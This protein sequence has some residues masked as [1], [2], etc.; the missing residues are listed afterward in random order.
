MPINRAHVCDYLAG[1]LRVAI[2]YDL[3]ITAADADAVDA[4]ASTC[5][6]EQ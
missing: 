4:G 6:S 2:A 1:Y 5:R 3:P